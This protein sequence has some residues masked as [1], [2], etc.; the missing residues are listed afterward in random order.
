MASK[1]FAHNQR[2][3][4]S[5]GNKETDVNVSHP[6]SGLFQEINQIEGVRKAVALLQELGGKVRCNLF[7]GG[8]EVKPWKKELPNA[9]KWLLHNA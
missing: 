1:L 6:P 8:H 2:F 7:Q 3:W 9:I 4:L 5:V